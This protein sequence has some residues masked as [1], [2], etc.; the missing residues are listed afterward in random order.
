MIF[1]ATRVFASNE[2]GGAQSAPCIVHQ[3]NYVPKAKTI[4]QATSRSLTVRGLM[5]GDFAL[6]ASLADHSG[7]I[8]T[9]Y[10]VTDYTNEEFATIASYDLVMK[11]PTKHI[12]RHLASSLGFITPETLIH[13]NIHDVMGHIDKKFPGGQY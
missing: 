9:P 5:L 4:E 3:V 8:T 10:L 13:L 12:T 6:I 2:D 7:A 1:E 11:E